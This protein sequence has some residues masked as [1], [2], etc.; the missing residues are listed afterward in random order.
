MNSERPLFFTRSDAREYRRVAH[1]EGARPT[2]HGRSQQVH[3]LFSLFKPGGHDPRLWRARIPTGEGGPIDE[4]L[5]R[6]EA[7]GIWTWVNAGSLRRRKVIAPSGRRVRGPM[8]ACTPLTRD[9]MEEIAQRAER[10]SERRDGL[11]VRAA[12]GIVVAALA[13]L[14]LWDVI[15]GKPGDTGPRL[16]ALVLSVM[17]IAIVVSFVRLRRRE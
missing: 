9:E 7:C 17:A 13:A 10:S 5:V 14:N 1:S 16:R 4:S 6:C 11:R 15:I 8:P 2:Q 3:D 12:L